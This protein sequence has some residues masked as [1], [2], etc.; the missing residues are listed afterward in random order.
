MVKYT[1][2]KVKQEE[3]KQIRRNKG[4][5]NKVHLFNECLLSIYCAPD[6]AVD[7]GN[8]SGAHILVMEEG[9]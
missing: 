5:N 9:R 2:R 8:E 1:R 7:A 4:T 6:A 3:D